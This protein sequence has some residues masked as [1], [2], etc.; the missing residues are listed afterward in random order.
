MSIHGPSSKPTEAFVA[1][2]DSEG[3]IM[4]ASNRELNAVADNSARIVA[5]TAA[6]LTLTPALHSNRIIVHDRAGGCIFT[7]PEATGT[8]DKY[9]FIVKTTYTSNTTIV[10][11]D[12]T[13]TDLI[14]VAY[15]QDSD[16][17]NLVA[18]FP[19]AATHDLCTLDGTNTGGGAGTIVEYIDIAT[20]LWSVKIVDGIGGTTPATPFSST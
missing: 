17:T 2:V 13:N 12:T 14:G 20:D 7:M 5:S 9:T 11:A 16:T 10:V 1:K 8:G 3:T 19:P 4:T 18:A 6:T 15:I